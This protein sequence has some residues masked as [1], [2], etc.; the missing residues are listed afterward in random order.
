MEMLL[1]KEQLKTL[2]KENKDLLK[3]TSGNGYMEAIRNEAMDNFLKLGFP[4]KKLESWKYTD[5]QSK[6]ELSYN[7]DL[8]PNDEKVDVRKIFQ[9]EIHNFET[10]LFTALNGWYVWENN[11]VSELPEGAFVG[12]IRAARKQFPELFEKHYGKYADIKTATQ[13]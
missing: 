8:E 3:Q 2:Y 12:S 7:Y 9:C 11:P 13:H 6:L 1:N 4:D 5:L 10:Y